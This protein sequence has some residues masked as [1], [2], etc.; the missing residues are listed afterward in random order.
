MFLGDFK[1]FE[2]VQDTPLWKETGDPEGGRIWK[3]FDNIIFLTEQMRQK[4]DLIY[5]GLLQRARDGTTDEDDVKLLNQQTTAARLLR[6]DIP[7]HGM[8]RIVKDNEKRAEINRIELLRFARE[9]KQPVYLFPAKT[10]T[11]VAA[12]N[13]AWIHEEILKVNRKDQWKGDGFF[14]YSKGMPVILGENIF[15]EGGFTNGTPGTS[16]GVTV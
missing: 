1:Q 15:T 4:N 11:P 5:Q 3:E 10:H 14:Q 13:R 8:T 7:P 12:P 6:G 16:E 9:R 2:P